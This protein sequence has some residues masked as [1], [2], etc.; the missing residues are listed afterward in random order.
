MDKLDSQNTTET[1]NDSVKFTDKTIFGLKIKTYI[2]CLVIIII[3]AGIIFMSKREHD[4]L[5]AELIKQREE[6][7]AE[8]EQKSIE[9]Q[10]LQLVK[11][12]M[13]T[14]EYVEYYVR[15]V[16]KYVQPDEVVLSPED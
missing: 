13:R 9:V 3:G 12:H 4:A 15:Y 16:L 8:Y 6:Y 1:K 10:N 14:P 7:K 5:N 11:Q 2:I